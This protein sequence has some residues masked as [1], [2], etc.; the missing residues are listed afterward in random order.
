LEQY[1]D[2]VLFS[3]IG[4]KESMINP[5]YFLPLQSLPRSSN[6]RIAG[7]VVSPSA[8]WIPSS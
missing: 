5:E 8:R 6:Q 4:K 7:A 1:F 3:S 2:A